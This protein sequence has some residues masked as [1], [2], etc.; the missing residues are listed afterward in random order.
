MTRQTGL[1]VPAFWRLPAP[2]VTPTDSDSSTI[3]EVLGH[4]LYD[5]SAVD[6]KVDEILMSAGRVSQSDKLESKLGLISA[7]LCYKADQR[8]NGESDR[9]RS[10]VERIRR[11]LA[12]P[13]LGRGIPGGK[14]QS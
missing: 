1:T 5:V 11:F 7:L 14:P 13:L 2:G 6:A 3:A 8:H 4:L 12:D 10:V 9:I